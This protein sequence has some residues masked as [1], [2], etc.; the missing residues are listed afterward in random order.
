VRILRIKD[1][2]ISRDTEHFRPKS[3]VRIVLDDE[4]SEIIKVVDEEGEAITH[5][6]YFWLAYHWQNLLPSCQFC[7]AAGG[8]LD[9]FPVQNSHIA[10]KRLTVS[11]IDDL[12]EKVTQS[13]EDP[14]VFYLEPRDLDRFEGRLLLHPITTILKT[15][16]SSMWK[17]GQPC[18]TRARRENGRGKSTTSTKPVS[19]TRAV[20]SKT[21]LGDVI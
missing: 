21:W 7:N 4:S 14:D 19:S 2:G 9:V 1:H 13:P 5:P 3:R 6:G 18:G 16:Y 20:R 8:K 15:T 10:V 12:L 17:A 11:E